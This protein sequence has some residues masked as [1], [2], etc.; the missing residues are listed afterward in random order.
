[1]GC[2]HLSQIRR[3]TLATEVHKDECTVCFETSTA[4]NGIDVCLTCFNGGCN[5]EDRNHS[6]LHHSKHRHPVVLNIKKVAIPSR[7]EN[8]PPQKITKLAIEEEN[9]E[10]KFETFTAVRCLECGDILPEDVK[11]NLLDVVDAVKTSL[12]ARKQSDVKAWNEELST[13]SHVTK[14][15]QNPAFKLDFK[16]WQFSDNPAYTLSDVYCYE[17]N[18]ERLDPSLGVHLSNFGINVS[19]QQKTEISIAELELEQNLK[20]DFAMVTEDGKDLT[21]LFGPGYTGLTNMGNTLLSSKTP[22]F[23]LSY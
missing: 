19:S 23:N 6:R 14:L 5:A 12:S 4:E 13:C 16:G 18:S 2:Q 9:S 3:P 8:S 20:F 15:V 17:C 10:D 7:T 21:P 11:G 1:M 22:V